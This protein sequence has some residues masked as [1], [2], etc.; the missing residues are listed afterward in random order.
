MGEN[1]MQVTMSYG[2]EGLK[3]NLPDDCQ[4][5]VINKKAM[6]ILDDP[7]KAVH[8]ALSQGV[9]CG[10]LRE[11]AQGKN[12]ACILICDITRPVPNGLL[13]PVIIKEL[14]AG[15]MAKENITVLVATGLH[16]PNEGDE[17]K[18]LVGSSW[19]MDN[20]RV[21]NHFARNDED[22]VE[23]GRTKKGTL[24][25]LDKRFAK[26][27]LRIATGLVEPHFM[28]G[29]SGGRKVITPGVAHQDTIRRIHT[30]LFME[31]P[32]AVN[33]QLEGN[34]LHEEQLEVVAMLGGA[35]SVNTVI[36]EHRELSFVN[37][38]EIQA[39]HLKAVEFVRPFAEVHLDK[40]YKTVVT[41]S[42][43]Y[44]L[45]K[46]YYQ[47]VKGMVGAME[48]LEPGGDIFIVSEISEGFGSPEYLEAQKRLI[49]LGLDGFL[50]DIM[51][52][53]AADIDEWQT[54]E[55][56]KPMRKGSVR[57]FTRSLSEEERRLTGV[58]IIDQLSALESAIA[59]SAAGSGK[60][61][62]I[63]EGPYILP[64]IK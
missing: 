23:L 15:G 13:L 58:E 17:L 27:D 31:D 61:A 40:T 59:Q 16:R 29:Y 22:H 39:S 19:V 28:A 7:E 53:Q 55:Q 8:D 54:E 48:I 4:I 5:D 46:T 60:I 45:D 38:G 44:P 47:T 51:P 36:T 64:F 42:A 63:P 33:C 41:S 26:A 43:G 12:S 10:P 24:V 25:K 52:K 30:A 57:L 1:A 34:P 56:L 2:R 11:E 37:F 32:K 35:L 21:E 50:Q 3:L 49:N 14:M 20:V 9:G 6:P 18:E 62:V